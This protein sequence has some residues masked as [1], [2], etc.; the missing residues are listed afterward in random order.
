MLLLRVTDLVC[1]V[2][3]TSAR[4]FFA[5]EKTVLKGVNLDLEENSSLA[6]VGESGCG[7]TTFARCLV[8]LERPV[9]GTITFHGE[10]IFPHSKNRKAVGL[11]MQL[12]FQTSSAAL[13][14]TLTVRDSLIEAVQA[15]RTKGVQAHIQAERLI[16]SVGMAPMSLERYP[17]HLSGGELQRVALARILAV[18]PRLL[19]LD[20]PTSAL[21]ALTSA[22][23][24]Q[25]LKS[26]QATEKFSLLYITHD[27]QMGFSFC[28]RAAVLHEGVI[29]E[30]G[31]CREVR[32]NPKHEYTARLIRESRLVEPSGE[33][34]L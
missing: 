33:D 18:A 10:N 11:E 31:L 27:L 6:L 12:L 34:P 17:R 28:D 30:S 5:R 4:H 14:P 15:R 16:A 20:E 23:L 8:G 7:K 25:L 26:L 21:D 9:S 29:V 3:N 32:R 2:R 24:L 19:I 13:D 22:H 1:S